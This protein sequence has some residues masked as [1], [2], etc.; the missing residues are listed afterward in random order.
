MQNQDAKFHPVHSVYDGIF[1]TATGKKIS[2][3]NPDPATID[4]EDIAI[5]LSNI[6][7]FGGN[8]KHF[9]SVAVH[10]ILVANI[11]PSSL[12]LE[13]LL[14][15]AAEAY[16]GDIIK[17]LKVILGKTY[18]D[19]EDRFMCSIITKFKLDEAKL[20]MIK[21]YDK[22]ALE[23]EHERYQKGNRSEWDYK[24]RLYNKSHTLSVWHLPLMDNTFVATAFLKAYEA[25]E[26]ARNGEEIDP[27][28]LLYRT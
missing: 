24:V 12:K 8:I 23:L 28:G 6:C 16:V 21:Q 26:K 14:H 7:R 17:P 11:A 18:T 9:Y 22:Q 27:N 15:D 2:I 1:N 3:L 25:L 20:A 4:I 13:A 10:S 5:A 19:I